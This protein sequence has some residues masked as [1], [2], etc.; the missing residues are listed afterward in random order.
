MPRSSASVLVIEDDADL[1]ELYLARLRQAGYRVRGAASGS[2]GIAAAAADP[3]A[4]VILD[5]LLPDMDGWDVARALR[6][7]P[8]TAQVPVLIASIVDQQRQV[9]ISGYLVKPFGAG[10]LRSAVAEI[11][12]GQAGAP[13]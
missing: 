3:P 8:A 2:A 13:A 1:R 11:L 7:D 9:Q 10:R 5:L 6:A 4:L 12:R